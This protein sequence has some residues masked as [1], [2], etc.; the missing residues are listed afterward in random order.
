MRIWLEEKHIPP[1]ILFIIMG[2][3]SSVW[4]LIRVIP[5]PSRATYPCIQV[6]A[7]IMSGFIIY[8][9]SLGG[10]TFLLRKTWRNLIRAKYLA[11]AGLLISSVIILII[12]LATDSSVTYA[13]YTGGPFGPED[14]ANMPMGKPLGL[15]PGRV[16]WAWNPDATNENCK[17]VIENNDWYFN[18]V[19]ADQKVI[20]NMVSESI[21]K[22]T[23][24]SN[25]KQA[26]D[27]LFRYQNQKKNKKNEGYTAGEKIFIKINQGTA[28]WALSQED[29]DKGYFVPTYPIKP[30]ARSRSN[31]A[32][33][34]SPYVVLEILR[35]LINEAG[36]KPSDISVGDPMAHI[37]GHNF[38]AWHNEFPDVKYI[39]KFADKFDRTLI[40]VTED[41]L[42]FYSDKKIKDK[43]YDVIEN[44]DYMINVASLK[45]H[46]SAGVSLTAKN[47]F[48]SQAR[49]GA[50]HLHYSSIAPTWETSPREV[51]NPSNGGYKKYRVMV[52]LLG[53][54][55]LGQNTMLYIVDGLFGGGADETKGPVKYFMAP[56]N[57]D[58]SNS[59]FSSQDEV[60]LESVCFDFLRSEWDG[61]NI[62]NKANNV[63]EWA[64]NMPGV[65][66]YLHQS[67]DSKNWPVGIVYDPDNSGKP[68][69][70]L[71]VHEHWNNPADKQ[72]SGN[73]GVKNGISLVSIP[74]NL[75]KSKEQLKKKKTRAD[76]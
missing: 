48:G 66:D 33:E 20:N 17:N 27:G 59:I 13:A 70:S 1:G 65:D 19:N 6:A 24:K 35:E 68:L 22:I 52:D 76:S 74:E 54:R 42:L 23:G 41:T 8:L 62:H 5:K 49:R 38:T 57:N 12:N 7:P 75:V 56:F 67:A 34:T 4:F 58:W 3:A 15:N 29:K 46:G 31:G 25:L 10:I 60:A 2:I 14:G 32:L 36:V 45:P 53:S 50:S 63:C 16:I 11:A 71:G 9:L 37:F 61:K 55:Y 40:K 26:W 30:G 18:T 69:G 73:L 28:S 21:L 51:G 47:H 44:A 43:L 64:P 72:Y 39:D